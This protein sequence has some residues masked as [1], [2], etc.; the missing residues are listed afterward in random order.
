[1]KTVLILA[2]GLTNLPVFAEQRLHCPEPQSIQSKP[3]AASL[4]RVFFAQADGINFT[5]LDLAFL[6]PRDFT[7]H[8]AAVLSVNGYWGFYCNYTQAT[9][10]LHLASNSR[11][12][13]AGC[14]FADG[15]QVCHG[16]L[17]DCVLLCSEIL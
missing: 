12:A 13:L 5:G 8:D 16:S 4:H 14:H 17:E 6:Q 2:L 1:M 11:P 15:A 9:V 3:L 7:F 10:S